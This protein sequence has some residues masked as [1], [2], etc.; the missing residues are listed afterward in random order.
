VTDNKPLAWG[1][2]VVLAL[3]LALI[4]VVQY[5][6]WID[7]KTRDSTSHADSAVPSSGDTQMVSM[8]VQSRLRLSVTRDGR[9]VHV[10]D[11]A[12]EVCLHEG[13][14]SQC[15]TAERLSALLRGKP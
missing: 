11:G 1:V 8:P 14:T 13:L 12:A 2:G 15:A 9:Q 6:D 5:A 10:Y 4:W 7:G 3:L